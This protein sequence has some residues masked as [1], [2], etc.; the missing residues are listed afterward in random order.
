MRLA[1]FHIADSSQE[2]VSSLFQEKHWSFSRPCDTRQSIPE[3]VHLENLYFP[4]PPLFPPIY[5]AQQVR[6]SGWRDIPLIPEYRCT[7]QP[8]FKKRNS[9]R[10]NAKM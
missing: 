4:Q 7:I 5:L 3:A 10:K 9:T 6:F 8:H 1:D 2:R